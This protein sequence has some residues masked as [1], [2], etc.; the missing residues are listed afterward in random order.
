MPAREPIIAVG[1]LTRSDLNL[2]GQSFDRLWPVEETPC[3]GAL[4]AAIDEAD[5]EFWR[6]A[7]GSEREKPVQA[8]NSMTI[9]VR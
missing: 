3:F 7:D 6:G 5:R 4:L 1:L 8:Q 9:K 2:L